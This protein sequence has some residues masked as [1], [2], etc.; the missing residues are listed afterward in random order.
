LE[1]EKKERKKP[2]VKPQVLLVPLRAEE[3]VLGF[4]KTNLSSGPLR[5]GCQGVAPCRTG[6]S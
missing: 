2:Y 5:A 4:C 3:A 6:G 1:T